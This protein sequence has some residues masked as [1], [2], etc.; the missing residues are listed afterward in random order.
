[1]FLHSSDVRKLTLMLPS[2]SNSK[3]CSS[4]KIEYQDLCCFTPPSTP[5]ELCPE[6]VRWDEVVDFGNDESTCKNAAAM[7]KREEESSDTCSTSREVSM[8]CRLWSIIHCS[9]LTFTLMFL[10]LGD[11]RSLLL[12]V[13]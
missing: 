1:M 8:L 10:N 12:R 4:V 5:C 2:Q 11:W 3:E 6:Y 7:L 9:F 13:V